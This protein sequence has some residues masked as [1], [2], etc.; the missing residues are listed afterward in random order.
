M[1]F[2]FNLQMS[3]SSRFTAALRPKEGEEALGDND[4]LIYA[5]NML[6]EGEG[7]VDFILVRYMLKKKDNKVWDI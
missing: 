3:L 1:Y 2:L 4:A 5:G 6:T 7:R